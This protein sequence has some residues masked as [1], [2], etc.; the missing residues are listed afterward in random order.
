MNVSK[1]LS[2]VNNILLP[3]NHSFLGLHPLLVIYYGTDDPVHIFQK[4]QQN[5]E[6]ENKELSEILF[7]CLHSSLYPH[8]HSVWQ[9]NDF[10][11][12]LNWFNIIL[13]DDTKQESVHLK[14][15]TLDSLADFLEVHEDTYP[16]IETPAPSQ[17]CISEFRENPLHL[18]DK[19]IVSS[20]G[21]SGSLLI[22]AIATTAFA[23]VLQQ[24]LKEEKW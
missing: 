21:N 4:L 18:E 13:S 14:L 5:S 10:L 19:T 1:S 24:S 6:Q 9:F 3:K 7:S 2:L 15:Q 8:D 16:F 22:P 23:Y 17:Y 12:D 11:V 20:N